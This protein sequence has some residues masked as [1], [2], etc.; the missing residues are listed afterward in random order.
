[1]TEHQIYEAIEEA[2]N[3]YL[4]RVFGL[5]SGPADLSAEDMYGLRG[6][7]QA[8]KRLLNTLRRDLGYDHN[9]L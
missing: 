6:E 7:I 4:E 5:F 9:S 1:M 3:S 8:A 2:H